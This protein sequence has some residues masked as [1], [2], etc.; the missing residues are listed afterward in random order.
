MVI[1][2][3]SGQS[4]S[5]RA[6][7]ALE[8]AGLDYEYKQVKIGST[9]KNGTQTD[10]YRQLNFQGKV[11]SLRHDKLIINES[12][13]I[14]NYIATLSPK[15][16]LIPNNDIALRAYYDEICS[17]VVT[18]LEQP[19]WTNGKHRFVLPKEQRVKDVLETTHLEFT[20][21]L[22]ALNNYIQDHQFVINEQF[23]MADI[24]ISHTLQWAETFKFKIPQHL[25]EYKSQMY[26]R[27][28]CQRAVEA[29]IES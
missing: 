20:K 6:L 15:A 8:E 7:W 1:L 4:R 12:I 21:S 13:A 3:G 27:P 19:L 28:A 11:P 2:Y 10:S 22:K 17:F 16:K 14:L 25:L 9:D 29:N 23:T 18:D 5:F 26:A 24:L